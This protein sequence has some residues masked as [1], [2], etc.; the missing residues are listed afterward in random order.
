[1]KYITPLVILAF[2]G[3]VIAI[4]NYLKKRG[5]KLGQE[6]PIYNYVGWGI[7]IALGVGAVALIIYVALFS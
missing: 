6:K 1:M 2:W 3:L 5:S 4:S 7:Y